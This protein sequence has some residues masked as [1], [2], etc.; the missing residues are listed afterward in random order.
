MLLQWILTT[1]WRQIFPAATYPD[2]LSPA[3]AEGAKFGQSSPPFYPSPWM[4]GQG[5]WA[6]AYEQAKAL[7]SQMTLLEK[8]NITTG[9]EFLSSASINAASCDHFI[10]DSLL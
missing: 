2:A 10:T 6:S 7:V 3:A 8:V 9:S 5:D 4:D 1:D